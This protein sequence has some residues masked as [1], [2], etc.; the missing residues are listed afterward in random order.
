MKE[1]VQPVRDDIISEQ[2]IAGGN[3][4]TARTQR[5]HRKGNV[6]IY[7]GLRI[8]IL[9]V[10]PVRPE[11]PDADGIGHIEIAFRPGKPVGNG[12]GAG[13]YPCGPARPEGVS[14]DGIVAAVP[15]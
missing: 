2:T 8:M 1:G 15:E 4:N 12:P 5:E 11:Y 14:I 9:I 13:E 7:I 3:G 6:A 10:D